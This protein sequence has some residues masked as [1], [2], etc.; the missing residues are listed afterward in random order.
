[1]KAGGSQILLLILLAE[2]ETIFKYENKYKKC[3]VISINF[4]ENLSLIHFAVLQLKKMLV[5]YLK[6]ER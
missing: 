1:M 6:E 2:S 3:E 5:K 4:A